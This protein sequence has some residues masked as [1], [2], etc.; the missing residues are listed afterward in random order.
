M[1]HIPNKAMP[2]AGGDPDHRQPDG[3]D[4]G[5]E[6]AESGGSGLARLRDKVRDNPKTAIAAGV[7][8]TAG[9][10]AAVAVPVARAARRRSGG[11]EEGAGSGETGSGEGESGEGRAKSKKKKKD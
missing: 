4:S 5:G 2:H 7:A 8:I 9:V 11:K 3:I 6:Q 10:A 1:S